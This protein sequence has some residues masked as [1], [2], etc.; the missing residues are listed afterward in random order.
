MYYDKKLVPH[1]NGRPVSPGFVNTPV[2]PAVGSAVAVAPAVASTVVTT[3]PT[4][5]TSQVAPVVSTYTAPVQSTT[6]VQE[7]A[8]APPVGKATT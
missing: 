1:M 3:A 5:V 2:A 4:L 6:V 8:S 7:V